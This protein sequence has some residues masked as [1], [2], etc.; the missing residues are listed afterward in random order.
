[1]IFASTTRRSFPS[2]DRAISLRF[3]NEEARDIGLARDHPVPDLSARQTLRGAPQNA[4]NVILRQRKILSLQELRQ[5]MRQ[6]LG[7]P[8]QVQE[9]GLFRRPRPPRGLAPR[10]GLH[11][12]TLYPLQQILSTTQVRVPSGRWPVPTASFSACSA[13]NSQ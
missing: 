4:Q 6:N 1:V 3:S 11:L 2:R 5:G 10:L 8:H 12:L 9:R 7:G 13:S